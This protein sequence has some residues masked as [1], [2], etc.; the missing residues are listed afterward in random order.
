MVQSFFSNL[1]MSF[2]DWLVHVSPNLFLV[3]STACGA[4]ESC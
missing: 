3:V 2:L 4:S 1:P